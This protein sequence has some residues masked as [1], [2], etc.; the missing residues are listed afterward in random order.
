[1]IELN[2]LPD[3]KQE[4]VHAK[5][6]KRL[7][8]VF[9]ILISLGSIA[10]V[11]LLGLYAYAAQPVR[12]NFADGDIKKLSKELEDKKNLVRDL[13]IQNQITTI[14]ELHAGKAVYG[15]LFDYLK[16]LN[17]EQPNNVSIS[18]VT[19]TTVD[20]KGAILLEASAKDYQAVAVF[21]DTLQN[22]MVQYKD[23][24]TGETVKARLFIEP[25]VIS[26]TGIGQDSKGN[27]VA[28]FKAA[29]IY[30][31]NAFAWTVHNP[32]VTVP[33]KKTNQSASNVPLF[34]DAP[35]KTAEQ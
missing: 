21:K 25:P 2:L 14:N 11:V 13:T 19:A 31:P 33:N 9:M 34:A 27:Q 29:L 22:A 35:V 12:Q 16:T 23:P 1:M 10:V 26:D 18:K 5:R 15:R 30:E 20:G 6:Q 17:P 7:V 4:F 28:S 3:I 8:I 24:E 32:K